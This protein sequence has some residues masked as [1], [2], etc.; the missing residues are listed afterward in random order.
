MKDR[1]KSR[2][3]PWLRRILYEM[4]AV[5]GLIFFS[6][7]M[8][9]AH[10]VYI[11]AWWEGDTVQTESYFG[12]KKKVKDG[13][14]KVFDLSGQRLLEGRTNEKGKF[15]FV[16]SQKTDF[17]IVVGDGTGHKNECILKAEESSTD[18]V[19]EPSPVQT[20]ETKVAVLPQKETDVEKIKT[21]VEQVLDSRLKPIQRELAMIR[22]EKGPGLSEIIGGVGYIFGLMGLAMYFKSRKK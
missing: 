7:S 1:C 5:I 2:K 8:V 10:K 17:R 16:P 4:V 9:F 20:E 18:S 11:Y 3:N 15:S 22:K 6:N 12:A 14:I 13:L 21:V 19:A